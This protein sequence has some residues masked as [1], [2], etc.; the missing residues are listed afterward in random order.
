MLIIAVIAITGIS[1]SAKNSKKITTGQMPAEVSAFVN[2][3]FGDKVISEVIR[4]SDNGITEYEI[5]FKGGD[6]IEVYADGAWKEIDCRKSHVPAALVP[7]KIAEYVAANYPNEK[8]IKIDRDYN[9]YDIELSNRLDID[10][11]IEGDFLHI[12]H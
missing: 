5:K 7:D 6:E 4:D 10:F 11:N 3:H 9:G 2:T 8:I 1:C 12:D